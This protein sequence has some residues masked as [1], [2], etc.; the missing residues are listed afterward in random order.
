MLQDGS[1]RLTIGLN[2]NVAVFFGVG[3]T[4]DLLVVVALTP[5]EVLTVAA[6]LKRCV[7][8]DQEVGLCNHPPHLRH[9]RVFLNDLPGSDPSFRKAPS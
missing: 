7:K 2:Q 1:L 5:V 3:Q 4:K 6:C 9:E 8:V